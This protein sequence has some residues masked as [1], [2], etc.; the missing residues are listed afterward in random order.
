MVSKPLEQNGLYNPT[1]QKLI[2]ILTDIVS[3]VMIYFDWKYLKKQM[4]VSDDDCHSVSFFC[5]A[6]LDQN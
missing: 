1:L 3:L 2:C 6:M 5:L 4:R